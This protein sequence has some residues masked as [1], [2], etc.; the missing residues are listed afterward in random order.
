MIKEGIN[1][2]LIMSVV[3]NYKNE[4]MRFI[5]SSL[6][7]LNIKKIDFIIKKILNID[8]SKNNITFYSKR[9][10]LD[11]YYITS[12]SMSTINLEKKI[13][14]FLKSKK[15]KK[16]DYYDKFKFK[17]QFKSLEFTSEDVLKYKDNL[18]PLIIHFIDHENE[19]KIKIYDYQF[20]LKDKKFYKRGDFTNAYSI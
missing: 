17:E 5:F 9:D 19:V 1:E 15:I 7:Y 14:D 10:E 18:P 8:I 13:I 11:K 3:I 20:K 6:R 2:D 12:L 16:I 4:E